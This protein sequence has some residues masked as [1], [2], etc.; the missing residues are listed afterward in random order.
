M[1]TGKTF[2]DCLI[3]GPA[4]IAAVGDTTFDGC[5]MGV[6]KNPHSLLYKAQGPLLV[7]VIGFK[8]CKFERCRFRQVGFTGHDDFVEGMKDKITPMSEDVA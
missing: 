2:T 7:G 1:I 4:V 6:T 5:D 3:E 8:D